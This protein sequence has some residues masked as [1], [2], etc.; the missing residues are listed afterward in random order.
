[1][2]IDVTW[3]MN[4][5][6]VVL[7]VALVAVTARAQDP[8]SDVA[9]HSQGNI[10]LTLFPGRWGF[11]QWKGTGGIGE[12]VAYVDPITLDSIYGCIFPRGSGNTF[13]DGFLIVGGVSDDDTLVSFG[14]FLIDSFSY[15]G[16]WRALSNDVSSPIFALEAKSELDLL[17]RFADTIPFSGRDDGDLW[18]I[19]PT[20]P[21]GVVVSQRSMAWS[22]SSV[23]DFVIIDF[24]IV[25]MG[26]RSLDKF[27][28][29]LWC[30]DV[31]LS[32]IPYPIGDNLTGFLRDS[33][34]SDDCDHKDTIDVGYIMDNDGDPVSG[35]YPAGS[36]RGA[37]GVRVLGSSI[38]KVEVGYTWF[39][40][41]GASDHDWGP[42]PAPMG[43]LTWRNFSPFL[44]WPGTNKNLYYVLSHPHIAYDQMFAAIPHYGWLDPWH[45]AADVAVGWSPI[46][47]YTFGPF[48]I[49]V[50]GH[51]NFTIAVVGGD[52]VHTNPNAILDPYNPQPF[53][54]QLDFSELAT[55]ARW[56]QWVYDNPGVD[57]D[58][59]GYFGEYRVC[60]GET[61]WYKGDGVPDFRGN[62][63]PPIPFTR[64]ETESGKIIVR[65]NGFL[66]ETTKD[67]FSGLYDFEGYRVYC[68][69]DN[70]RTSLSLLTSYDKQDW[71]RWKFH[72]L[73]SGE[74]KWLNDDPPFSLDSLR[75]IHGDPSFD[76]EA[77]PRQ[78]PLFEGDSTFYFSAVDANANSLTDPHGIHKAYPDAVNPGVDS[79]FWTD[80]DITT[81]HDGRKLPKYYEYEYVIDNLLPTVPYFVAVTVFDFGY[82]GGRGNMPPDET[83]PLNNVTECYAQTS[84]EIVEEQQLDVYVY[85]NPYRADADYEDNGYENRKGNIIPDRARLIHFGNLPKVCKIKIYS[86]DGDHIGTID[87]NF[88]EGGPESMHDWWNL[89]SRSG[90]AVESGLYFWVVESAD[91]TQIGKLVILK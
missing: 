29:G 50:R 84:S 69:L 27:Y 14:T 52:N 46:M 68:G 7:V 6:R 88:P 70:R 19:G 10:Q 32:F 21:T 25:N 86:L 26:H 28:V 91:R 15:G 66:S 5:C 3:Q 16:V 67:N 64:Y 90:L 43:D 59:D 37:V 13:I 75:A 11:P 38:G 82:A 83:N 18:S 57:T 17:C 35:R 74:G 60:E 56:A 23:D 30:D 72:A 36:R 4:L 41:D 55:N 77:Y 34:A 85:P 53:Y 33:P 40:W 1:M 8:Y 71:F 51:I 24:D 47:L 78:R 87:H 58:S 44:A 49:D 73:G 42:R 81:E 45:Y 9:A 31:G 63:P 62:T 80:D 61:T 54:D 22:G 20:T 65:W 39:L 79:T 76:P 12:E 48:E 89:V 2:Y